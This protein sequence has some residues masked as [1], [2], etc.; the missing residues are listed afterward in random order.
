[1]TARSRPP[2]DSLMAGF[3][4]SRVQPSVFPDPKGLQ[5][6]GSVQGE[7]CIP[8]TPPDPTSACQLLCTGR[9]MWEYHLNCKFNHVATPCLTFSVPALCLQVAN[10]ATPDIT[11]SCLISSLP[12]LTAR[13]STN[14]PTFPKH[15]ALQC[16]LSPAQ[17]FHIC[18]E[19]APLP[20]LNIRPALTRPNPQWPPQ[21]GDVPVTD[22]VSSRL[23][24]CIVSPLKVLS[25]HF[26]PAPGT[27]GAYNGFQSEN[28]HLFSGPL[29]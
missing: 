18:S 2:R 23:C 19:C 8:Q 26:I 22:P 29:F 9:P 27:W 1:M 21:A 12:P 3:H 24:S 4:R 16:L 14:V 15:D 13:L 17:A 5:A 28:K 7:T 10:E 6:L 20:V 11:S 25:N